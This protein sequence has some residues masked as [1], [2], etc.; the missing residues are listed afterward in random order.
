MIVGSKHWNNRENY[1]S[2]E[3]NPTEQIL[4][5]ED[6]KGWLET[7]GP[8]AAVN[9]LAALGYDLSVNCPG[10]YKPQPEEVLND[11]FH[12]PNNYTDLESIRNLDLTEWMGNRVPQY[13]PHAVKSVFDV[14]AEFKYSITW[15]KLVYYLHSRQAVQICLKKPGHYIAV[16][17]Y[18]KDQNEIIFNDPWPGR[19][20]D[21]NG[22][23]R[24]MT[25]A[26]FNR[27][28]KPFAII[29]KGKS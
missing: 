14:E 10:K 23:N 15:K 2:Q 16:V 26:E 18:D 12:D 1:F 22:F 17:A 27:N 4:K 28:V 24:K 11:F 8:T 7:C 6:G 20:R 29:Y 19:F 13:Y 25:V 21:R 5:K 9:C 3:N